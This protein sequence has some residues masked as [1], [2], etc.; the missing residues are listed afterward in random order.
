M[1]N[2]NNMIDKLKQMKQVASGTLGAPE[3]PAI[4]DTDSDIGSF[5]N[6]DGE[7][8]DETGG[9]LI[10]RLDSG[11][12]IHIPEAIFK[13]MSD[14]MDSGD[15]TVDCADNAVDCPF[16][17]DEESSESEESEESEET[18]KSDDSSND[19][20]DDNDDNDDDK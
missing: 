20:D 7:M 12:E 18:E 8:A 10:L 16:N 11:I 6:I 4:G 9:N 19:D 14:A 15:P 13:M 3:I 1:E 17:T 2:F 5:G